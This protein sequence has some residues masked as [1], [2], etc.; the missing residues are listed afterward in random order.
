M[1]PYPRPKA[2]MCELKKEGAA[3]ERKLL[4]WEYGA[5]RP[6]SGPKYCPEEGEK[7]INLWKTKE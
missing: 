3:N 2:H 7:C 6:T 5:V 4:A 1:N